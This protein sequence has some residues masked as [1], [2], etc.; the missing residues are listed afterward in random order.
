MTNLALVAVVA[1]LA[2][3]IPTADWLAAAAG[4]DLRSGGSRNPGA[5]NARRLGGWG[6]AAKVLGVEVAK[7]AAI[8]VAARSAAGDTAA[9]V[10]GFAAV[11]GNLANPWRRLRGGQGLGISAGVTLAVWPVAFLPALALI[12]IAVRLLHRSAPA[13]LITVAVYA[14]AAVGT[15]LVDGPTGWGVDPTAGL[16]WFGVSLA[17]ALAPK[18]LRRL[19]SPT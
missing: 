5:N 10:A 4:V 17:A 14:A 9:L 11:V 2:G 18:Q 6:L 3:G 12:G 16:G 7:G 15:Q 13:T 1:Y 19:R 8:V